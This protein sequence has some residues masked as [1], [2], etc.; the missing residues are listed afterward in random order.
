MPFPFAPDSDS[1]SDREIEAA[2]AAWSRAFPFSASGNFALPFKR[3]A[4]LNRALA[5]AS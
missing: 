2:F 5:S 3:P 4:S 1:L